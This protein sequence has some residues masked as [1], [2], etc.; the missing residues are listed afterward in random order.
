MGKYE[1][2]KDAVNYF[3]NEF[4]KYGFK[5][6]ESPLKSSQV[7]FNVV[8]SSSKIFKIKV[9]AIS[10]MGSYVFCKKINFNIED[11]RL[12]MAVMYL[13]NKGNLPHLYLVPATE[14][15]KDIYPFKGKD[16][17][18][19]GQVSEPEWGINFSQRAKDAMGSYR[20]SLMIDDLS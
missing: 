17:G 19:P 9:K 11:P 1:L 15:G 10:K 16:Y 7:D 8:S 18:K 20:F 2:Y 12:F 14:W 6:E 4:R 5:V 13:P 3:E